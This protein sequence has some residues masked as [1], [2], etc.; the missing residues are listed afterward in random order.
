M[1]LATQFTA[2]PSG[3]AD[4]LAQVAAAIARAKGV[5]APVP[6]DPSAPA[7]K[8]AGSLL[9][10][11]RKAVLLG[12]AA[13]QHPQA[14][15]LLGLAHWIGNEVGATVGYFGE[16]A[17]SV[18]AQWVG[19]LPGKGGLHAGQMLARPMKALLLLGVEPVFD[20][21]DAAAARDA[22]QGAGLVVSLSPFKDANVEFADVL[23]PVAPFSETAGT[24]VNAEGRA[25]SFHG[26][27]HPL[28]ETRPAWKV[29]RVLGNLL[30]LPGFEQASAEEVRSEALGDVSTLSTRLDNR[31]VAA[32]TAIPVPTALERVAD[33]PIYSSD[34]L[35]R[36]A[37]SLQAT[38]DARPP[39][40]G[41]PSALWRS[42]GL[43]PGDSLRVSQ[44]AATA[45]LPA[46]E[47]ASLA[48]NAVRVAAGHASTTTLGPMFGP[49]SV[50]A[51]KGAGA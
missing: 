24:F 25:Q 2:A 31:S 32:L 26:V 40:V 42:L 6:A 12:N 7:Q 51:V 21:A 43:K 33:V 39:V 13:A 48:A 23:L 47:D 8:I 30:G 46:R 27:V 29:L 5:A 41:L 17:N 44:G 16:A 15:Q 20:A 35:V 19:A 49:V 37:P 3:W 50:E 10:G 11:E 34:A 9:S 28:G 18:G 36:R 1:P 14:S 22:L 38:A 4:A 45:V